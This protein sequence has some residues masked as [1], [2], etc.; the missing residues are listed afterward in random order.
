M[1]LSADDLQASYYCAAREIR[2]RQL[3]GQP[4]PPPVQKLFDRL[5]I[6]IRV[7]PAGRDSGGDTAQSDPI[8]TKE[9]AML[10][11]LSPRQVRRIA[12]DLDGQLV[13]GRLLFDRRTVPEYGEGK[14]HG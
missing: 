4:V 11:G 8:G 2:R 6:E 9:A 7:S 12:A 5:D 10:L 14:R 3:A 13:G 1:N